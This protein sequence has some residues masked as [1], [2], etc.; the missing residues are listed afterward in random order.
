MVA[1]HAQ[2]LVATSGNA[3]DLA[4]SM[5]ISRNCWNGVV[6]RNSNYELGLATHWMASS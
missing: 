5:G 1:I 2:G 4:K 6:L 3:A